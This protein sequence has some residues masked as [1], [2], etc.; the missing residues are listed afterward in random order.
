MPKRSLD[1]D[2]QDPNAVES[3]VG[4]VCKKVKEMLTR[5]ALRRKAEKGTLQEIPEGP[6]DRD[7]S[8]SDATNNDLTD[9]NQ[10]SVEEGCDEE[11]SC[12][13]DWLETL[14]IPPLV[15]EVKEVDPISSSVSQWKQWFK[16]GTPAKRRRALKYKYEYL[17]GLGVPKMNSAVIRVLPRQMMSKDRS[18]ATYHAALGKALTALKLA[19]VTAVN[20]QTDTAGSDLL[21][22]RFDDVACYMIDIMRRNVSARR[23]LVLCYGGIRQEAKRLLARSEVDSF[24]FGTRLPEH[25][26]RNG[27]DVKNIGYQNFGEANYAMPEFNCYFTPQPVRML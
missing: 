21:Q 12:D 20:R 27:I 13:T 4:S 14:D 11:T 5:I 6:S 2:A 18:I 3:E 15:A 1:R 17:E 26:R 23:K 8:P 22:E 10:N 16:Y 9:E 24:L 7:K 19:M 25:L